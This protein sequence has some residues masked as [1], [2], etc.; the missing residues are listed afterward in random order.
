MERLIK[1]E[2][3]TLTDISFSQD[4]QLSQF[5]SVRVLRLLFPLSECFKNALP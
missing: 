4:S 2:L 1:A 5:R 3:F